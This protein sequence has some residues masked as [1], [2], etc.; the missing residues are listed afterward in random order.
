[1]CVSNVRFLLF[2]KYIVVNAYKVV[3]IVIMKL[4]II[5]TARY[6]NSKPF[7]EIESARYLTRYVCKLYNVNRVFHI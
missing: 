3:Y 5:S 6:V 1:M 4:R 7:Y 2:V